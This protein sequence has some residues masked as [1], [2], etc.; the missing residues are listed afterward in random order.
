M[1]CEGSSII[2][3]VEF[4]GFIE[5]FESDAGYWIQLIKRCGVSVFGVRL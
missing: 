4:V 2:E 5:L 1:V 3:Y